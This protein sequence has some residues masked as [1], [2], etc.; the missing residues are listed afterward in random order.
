MIFKNLTKKKILIFCLALFILLALGFFYKSK[1]IANEIKQIYQT[2]QSSVI[3]DRQGELIYLKPNVLGYRAE[4]SNRV[5]DEF[6]RLLLDKEDKYFYYHWGIN[7]VSTLRAFKNYILGKDN[8]T[9]ST[10]TQQLVKIILATETERN[11]KNKFKESI[12]AI[13]L[14]LHLNK[15]EI[16]QMYVNSVYLGN[17]AQGLKIASRL[18]F[19]VAPE[20]LSDV[21]IAQ[22]LIAISNPSNANPFSANT[23]NAVLRLSQR[24]NID[25]SQNF[26]INENEKKQRKEYHL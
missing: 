7:P 12:Y 23:K 11:F 6:K 10:I 1:S 17:K 24:L 5:P 3:Y 26:I 22:L 18:Y 19:G 20:M 16:L 21:K 9:S 13:G 4:Y 2:R 25:L 15:D 8:L 14:E